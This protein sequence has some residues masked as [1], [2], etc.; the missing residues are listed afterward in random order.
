MACLFYVLLRRIKWRINF[1]MCGICGIVNINKAPID[2]GVIKAMAQAMIHRG[3]NDEGIYSVPGVCLGHRRLS[4]IDLSNAGHQPLANEDKTIWVILNGEIY[5]YKDLRNKLEKKGHIFNSNSDTEVIVHLYEEE[6][7]DCVKSMIG[8]FA[9]GIWDSK[10]E[11]LLLAR[12]RIGKKP[13]LYSYTSGNFCFASE[14]LALL[15]SSLIKKEINPEALDYYLT[16]GYIPA[17]LTIY[18]NVFKLMPAHILIFKNG[19]IKIERYWQLDYE[20]KTKISEDEAESE[21]LRL[22][23]DSVKIRL[24]SDVPLGVFL[25]G[26]IDSSMVVGLMSK[27]YNHRIKTFSIGFDEADYNELRY[28][29]NIA[30]CFNTD[31]KEFIVKP[32]ALDVLPALVEHYGEPFADSS[33]IPTYYVSK[34]SKQYVTVVLS[35][36]GADEL[37]AGYERYEAMIYSEAFNRLPTFLKKNI[38]SLLIRIIPESNERRGLKRK[39]SRFFE[40]AMLP[41]HKR[42]IKWIGIFDDE[43]KRKIYSQDFITSSG[44]LAT[45][46]FFKDCLSNSKNLQLV[47]RLLKLDSLTYL[48]ND[49]LV[50]VDI[51]SMANALETRSPFLD[52]RLMEFI[53]S[54]PPYFKLRGLTKKYLLKK[55]AT[56]IIP[57]A[58]IY[59]AKQGFGVPIGQWFRTEL[60]DLLCDNLLGHT[61]L[62]RGYFKPEIVRGMVD[63]HLS[64]KKDY[65][66]QLWTLLMLE[67]WHRKFMEAK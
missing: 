21:I 14:F 52:H 17:P 64:H 63:L 9:F 27:V 39:M 26:G 47:D 57:K 38:V 36:D 45:D 16:F 61:F 51:A 46:E 53:V 58:N 6:G 12:D 60:R 40:A 20:K 15:R 41:M 5:N 31:H 4:I 11:T 32:N 13:L 30:K 35:G 62:N 19:E 44:N 23:L 18:K 65:S 34:M 67:L 10:K 56:K 3:P 1:K 29:R 48:P 49:L 22:L 7:E 8:M 42:Y 28:A 50:K 24:Y 25:S 33:C 43:L 59:R 66:F 37:F 55:I 54:L 2:E